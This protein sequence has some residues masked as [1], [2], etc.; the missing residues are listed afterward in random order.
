MSASL[1]DRRNR[2]KRASKNRLRTTVLRLKIP[3]R[4]LPKSAPNLSGFFY[5]CIT[6]HL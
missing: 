5:L 1:A 2:K 6:I 4:F 3:L